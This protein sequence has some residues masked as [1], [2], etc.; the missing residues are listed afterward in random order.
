MNILVLLYFTAF[1]I[2]V[3]LSIA[4]ITRAP[5]ERLNQVFA[6]VMLSFAIWTLCFTFAQGT[7]DKSTALLWLY[8]SSFGGISYVSFFLWFFLILTK[9]ERI[10]KS[11]IFYL[12]I[13][14]IPPVFIYNE[15]RSNIIVDLAPAIFGGWTYVWSKSIWAYLFYLYYF[16]FISAGFWICFNFGRK[17]QKIYEKK[18]ARIIVAT[19]TISLIL[20]TISEVILPNLN[21]AFPSVVVITNLIW[22]G[23]IAYAITKYKLMT[24]TPAAAAEDILSVMSD[25]LILIGPDGRTVETNQATLSLLGYRKKEII[26]KPAGMLFEE[27]L[28][29]GSRLEKLI[30]DSYVKNYDLTFRTKSGEKIPANLS[31]SVMHSTDGELMGTVFVARDMSETRRFIVALEDAKNY[32]ENIVDSMIDALIVTDVQGKITRINHAA[33][34]LFVNREGEQTGKNENQIIGRNVAEFFPG[35]DF[36]KRYPSMLLQNRVP[37][38]GH[39]INYKGPEGKTIPLSLSV[40]TVVDS[41]NNVIGTVIILRDI[42]TQKEMEKELKH[43]ATHDSM[44]GLPNRVLLHDR[45]N[46]ALSRARRYHCYVSI[47]LLDIDNFKEINDTMGHDI[48]D[49]LLKNASVRIQKCLRGSDTLARMGGDEFIAVLGDLKEEQDAEAVAN[50]I[51]NVFKTPFIINNR[52]IRITTSMGIG[53]YP[54]DGDNIGTLMKAADMAVYSAKELGKNRFCYFLP[55]IGKTIEEKIAI[56]ED[57]QIAIEREE[58][59]L[60]YQPLIETGSGK[61]VAA[62]ALLRWNHP[63]R[64]IIG[65]LEFIPAAETTGVIVP[66]GEWVLRTACRQCKAWQKEGF[67]HI[68]VSVNISIYQLREIDFVDRVTQILQESKLSPED[69]TMEITESAAMQNSQTSVQIFEKLHQLGVQIAID[70]FG[71]GYS[72]FDLLRKL[73]IQKLKI[74]RFL[75]QNIVDDPTVAAIV[76]AIIAMAYSLGLK[77]VAEGV[78]TRQQFDFLKTLEYPFKGIM[79]CDLVQGY[80]FSRPVPA[81]E[82][83]RLVDSSLKL[84]SLESG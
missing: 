23:G 10:L 8:I 41:E 3:W 57:L 46:Q 26:G 25:S 62:E 18:Q 33:L 45:A 31:G 66:I 64:G 73:P 67:E 44:T 1:L 43:M 51:L 63:Q 20:G 24:I 65:P 55:S 5:K 19:G 52:E 9:K 17:T 16:V 37:I 69:L 22:V 70:D 71:S 13:F 79:Q 61:V 83:S 84:I 32:V 6:L 74:D 29:T 76:K 80:L 38:R 58:F 77:V 82:F 21:I 39:E 35:E 59:L 36:F 4:V 47:L 30:R 40:S 78:E 42:T 27:E 68:S 15:W 53:I 72:S 11:W 81:E 14:S 54:S 49:M 56:K 2:Y 12:V 28:F 7:T 60:H 75:V 48:G 50:K 34:N